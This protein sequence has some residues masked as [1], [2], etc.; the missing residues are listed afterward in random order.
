MLDVLANDANLAHLGQQAHVPRL[1]LRTASRADEKLLL[2]KAGA[3]LTSGGRGPGDVGGELDGGALPG[4]GCEG[5]TRG[6][7]RRGKAETLRQ[8]GPDGK[9]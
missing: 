2:G 9:R 7:G 4:H 5:A 3:V 6:D 1:V 8:A